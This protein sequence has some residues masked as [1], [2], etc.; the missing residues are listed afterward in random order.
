MKLFRVTRDA[1]NLTTFHA[2]RS[3][4]AEEI[5]NFQHDSGLLHE[6]HRS[7]EIVPLLLANAAEVQKATFAADQVLEFAEEERGVKAR[8][9]GGELNRALVNFLTAMRLY[10]DHTETRLKRRY[11]NKAPVV[12]AFTTAASREFDDSAAYRILYKLR[13]YVQHC[14]LPVNTAGVASKMGSKPGDPAVYEVA[15]GATVRVL[16]ETYASWGKAKADLLAAGETIM[17]HLYV[18]S[19]LEALERIERKTLTAEIP[20][21][22]GAAT[23]LTN[24]LRE[25]AAGEA[26]PVV[27]TLEMGDSETKIHLHEPPYG[28]LALFGLITIN[29]DGRPVFDLK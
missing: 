12:R 5:E 15:I 22:S 7:R 23:R 29:P 27:V 24:L 11:G 28:V 1:R 9:A 8:Q 13:N 6:F 21:L 4:T 10:L 14:G 20:E 18:P 19:V 2:L 16:L 3:L 17:P 26:V 25:G